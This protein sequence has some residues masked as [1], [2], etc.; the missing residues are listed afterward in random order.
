MNRY[1]C[2]LPLFLW[3]VSCNAVQSSRPGLGMWVWPQTAFSTAPARERLLAFCAEEGVVHLDQ[4]VGIE[5]RPAG[6]SLKNAEALAA[7]VVAARKQ[8][9][10]VNALRGSAAMFFER[11]HEGTLRDL[12]AIVRFDKR[13]PKGTHL[14]G[15]KYDVE[16]Y[17]TKEWKAGG[18]ERAKVMLDYL[19]FLRKAK[20]LLKEEAPHL[21]LCVDVPFWWDAETFRV[22][23]GGSEKLFVEHVMD[24]TDDIGIM[25]YR[26]TSHG[27][28]KCIRQEL[29]YAG[30]VGK[31]ICPG[32]ETGNIQGKES[33]ISFWGRPV[34]EFR[35]AVGELQQALAGKKAVKCIMLHHYSSLVQY[36]GA[37]PSKPDAGDGK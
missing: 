23:F 6:G 3:A 2:L 26:P 30:K 16:P 31:R 27:V 20:A 4:H 13:L 33:W 7:L 10:T 9:V 29:A 18:K 17:G 28:L 8:G 37:T 5:S 1:Y 25:S 12:R 14:A 22:S 34:S 35:Q 21:A 24:L 15:V 11:N 19:S 32:L 36:L